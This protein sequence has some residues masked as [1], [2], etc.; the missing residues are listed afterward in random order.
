MVTLDS[1]GDGASGGVTTYNALDKATAAFVRTYV[2]TG[3]IEK[4][5]KAANKVLRSDPGDLQQNV[6][7]EVKK[8][9]VN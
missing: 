7:D 8:K 9:K 1:R 4:A 3:N 6:G 2:K 5:V